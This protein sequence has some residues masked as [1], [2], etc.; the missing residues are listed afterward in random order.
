M[1]D[2][3]IILVSWNTRDLLIAC[4]Q[5][6]GENLP[7]RIRREVIVV[8]NGSSD[9]SVP[10]VRAAFPDVRLI[11]NQTN[12]GFA[13]ANNQG[14]RV[15]GGRAILLL[16]S[17]TIVRP[18]AIET[19]LETQKR[20]PDAGIIGPRLLN[21]DGSLQPSCFPAPTLLR[22][23]WRLFHLDALHPVGI[24]PVERWP[25]DTSRSVDVIQGACM[26]IRRE[27]IEHVGLLEESFYM[28]SE[29]LDFC[30]RARRRGWA[31][32]WEPRA[33]VVHWGGQSTRQL[34][35]AMFLYLYRGK[36]MYFRKHHG[37]VTAFLYKGI[38]AGASLARLLLSPLVWPG[39]RQVN[40][41]RSQLRES[42]RRLL[43]ALPKM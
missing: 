16:N 36:V 10:A 1:L 33:T 42:Y 41:R 31:V 35:E 37:K 21:P 40:Q 6:L 11:E 18:G 9:G 38:L 28:Y 5:A 25:V 34:A 29:E 3:S 27:V 2:L 23:I 32:V 43:M 14:I 24:Y 30:R 26:L 17:D 7:E 12:P 20:L 8:D 13:A 39:R 19:L 22:E 15:S 4:L